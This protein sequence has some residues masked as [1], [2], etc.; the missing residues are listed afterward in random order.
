MK[1][2]QSRRF[3]RLRADHRVWTRPKAV[4]P[5]PETT[6]RDDSVPDAIW[7]QLQLDNAVQHLKHKK[8]YNAISRPELQVRKKE[9]QIAELELEE[10][11]A[12]TRREFAE[13]MQE[14]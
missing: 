11:E 14:H 13:K 4:S 7:N 10:T 3:H 8:L 1:P 9:E 2:I 12:A 6:P 5:Q